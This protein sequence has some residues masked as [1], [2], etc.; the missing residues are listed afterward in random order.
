LL[1]DHQ[2][3]ELHQI[4]LISTILTEPSKSLILK[5]KTDLDALTKKYHK[6]VERYENLKIYNNVLKLS[7]ETAETELKNFREK[8]IKRAKSV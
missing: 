1:L 2:N 7:M 4:E 3:K 6:L 5:N 8:N